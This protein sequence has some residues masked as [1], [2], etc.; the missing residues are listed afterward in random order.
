MR[1]ATPPLPPTETIT[2]YKPGDFRIGY[3]AAQAL[4]A[5]VGGQREVFWKL[6][7]GECPKG[8]GGPCTVT[9]SMSILGSRDGVTSNDCVRAV[10]DDGNLHISMCSLA[11]I[12]GHTHP[13]GGE[14]PVPSP[15]DTHAIAQVCHDSEFGSHTVCTHLGLFT[16]RRASKSPEETARATREIA[17]AADTWARTLLPAVAGE[18]W[19]QQMW[20]RCGMDVTYAAWPAEG[21]AGR[22]W[23]HDLGAGGGRGARLRQGQGRACGSQRYAFNAGLKAGLRDGRSAR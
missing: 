4:R 1:M 8:G 17:S 12:T 6:L 3:E 15:M 5:Y 10:A 23:L 11:G 18:R 16:L 13:D 14:G 2:P 9:D 21:D 7:D 19:A 20:D 22:D